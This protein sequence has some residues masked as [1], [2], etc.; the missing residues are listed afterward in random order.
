MLHV[1][2]T[3]GAVAQAAVAAAVHMCAPPPATE[4]EPAARV[5]PAT[6]LPFFIV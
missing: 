5:T 4:Q 2:I 6:A 1:L 3:L